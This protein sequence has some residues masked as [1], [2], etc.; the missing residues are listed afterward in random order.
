[1][2][3]LS[4]LISNLVFWTILTCVCCTFLSIPVGLIANIAGATTPLGWVELLWLGFYGIGVVGSAG[5]F[6]LDLADPGPY[7]RW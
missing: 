4:N 3:A 7:R 1:M 5:N 2:R 6:L